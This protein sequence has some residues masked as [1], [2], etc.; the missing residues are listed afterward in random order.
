MKSGWRL[1]IEE[2]VRPLYT[3]LDGVD[4]FGEVTALE[5]RLELLAGGVEHDR[6]R[7]ALLVLFHG[8]VPRL[9]S[10]ATGGRWQLLLR[11]IGLE[12][13]AIRLL[14]AGLGRFLTNPRTAEEALLHDALLLAR[15]GVRAAVTR[16]LAAGRKKTALDQ[17]LAQLDPG[18]EPGRFLT[19]LGK[20]S[21]RDRY[22]AASEWIEQLRGQ[23][24]R[25]DRRTAGELARDDHDPPSVVSSPSHA[26]GY[27]RT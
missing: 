3:E 21:A 17:A 8:V 18:P 14:R 4:T 6:D 25:E 11:G 5:R 24:S 12:T 23:I 7:L 13:E 10:L 15:S 27:R 2:L 22:R 19:P 1:R 16:L 26:G 9:G 20:A